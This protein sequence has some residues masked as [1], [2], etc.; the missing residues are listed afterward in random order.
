[1]KEQL[2]VSISKEQM[3]DQLMVDALARGRQQTITS[4]LMHSRDKPPHVL[5]ASRSSGGTRSSRILVDKQSSSENG[6]ENNEQRLLGARSSGVLPLRPSLDQNL[7]CSQSTHTR[8]ATT[9]HTT[10]GPII[11]QRDAV[12]GAGQKARRV[13]LRRR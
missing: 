6:Q 4:C 2:V 10:Q 3:V 8:A 5:A 11:G 12:E 1:M 7:L 9:P 13:R